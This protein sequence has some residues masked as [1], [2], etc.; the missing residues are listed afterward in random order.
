MP[1]PATTRAWT[2]DDLYAMPDD[3]NK[4]EVMQGVSP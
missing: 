1:M 4:Y 3:G 2:L